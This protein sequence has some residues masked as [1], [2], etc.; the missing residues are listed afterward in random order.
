MDTKLDILIPENITGKALDDLKNQYTILKEND[1]WKDTDKFAEAA[2]SA[3]AILVRNQA[4]VDKKIIDSADTLQIIGRAG[5]GYDNIDVDYA[6]KKGVVVCYTPDGNTIATAELAVGLMI[7]LARKIPSADRSTKAGNWDRQGH[8]G[9]EIYGKTLGIVGFGKIGKTV[10]VRAN[11]FG[12]KVIAYDKYYNGAGMEG[13]VNQ[14]SSLDELL[15]QSDV[16]TVHLPS[17]K[18]TIGLFNTETYN[19]IKPGAYLI[20]TSRGNVIVEEDLIQALESGRLKGVA[21]DV[22]LKEP[23]EKSKL[24]EMDNVIFT[25]HIGG[26]TKESQDKVINSIAHDIELVLSGQPSVNFINFASPK[27]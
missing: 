21:L 13:I 14:A 24:N 6:S 18:D 26:F 11:A 10:A 12:M 27:R 22:R 20:N 17:T 2:K 7:S 15:G 25:P 16:I 23:P 4:K 5:V 9:V 8:F 1:L 19:K 3:K